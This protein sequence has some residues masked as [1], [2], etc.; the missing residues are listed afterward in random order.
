[1]SDEVSHISTRRR[2]VLQ[3][4]AGG[5]ALAGVGAVVGGGSLVTSASGD[6]AP[7]VAWS[8]Q[9][10]PR[11]DE[12]D[13][14]QHRSAIP[15]AVVKTADGGYVLGG[16]HWRYEDGEVDD[17]LLLKTDAKGRMQWSREYGG[18]GKD[19]AFDLVQTDDGGYLLVGLRRAEDED[20]E[21]SAR[22][23]YRTA[24]A[25]KTDSAGEKQWETSPR[26]DQRG[27][28][29]AATQTAGGDLVLAGFFED[30]D[31]RMHAWFVRVDD[32]G[33]TLA[34]GTYGDERPA[35][36]GVVQAPDE[37]LVFSGQNHR[38]GW[39][40]KT[41]LSGNAWW[42]TALDANRGRA[43]DVLLT[44]DGDVLVTGSHVPGTENRDLYLTLLDPSGTEQ[45]TE[46]HG[47]ERSEG[48]TAL[49]STDDGGYVVVG[50]SA[51]R[52][53]MTSDVDVFAVK[54]DASG[55]AEWQ[56]E[57]LD[58]VPSW[59]DDVVQSPDGG[60]AITGYKHFVKIGGDYV[61]DSA[62]PTPR[63]TSEGTETAEDTPTESDGTATSDET[64]TSVGTE[65]STATATSS[66]DAGDDDCSIGTET[67]S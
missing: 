13:D 35:F 16:Y 1:M 60:Y 29:E 6:D 10:D 37:G 44:D 45:W 63:P 23:H 59:G 15:H 62:T 47:G 21:A 42:E 61:E 22:Q 51:D 17:F 34:E 14:R 33:T 19:R 26:P 24:W 56:S 4:L 11:S 50:Q 2:T 25:V 7:P 28:F 3:G 32:T 8:R 53:S 65:T 52:D 40:L 12:G 20:A 39:V 5:A 57:Y 48:G 43:E 54:T 31:E 67:E 66:S 58:T 46:F 27:R 49:A 38:H 18:Q 9:Y 41:D 64:A 36:Y 55:T 30:R